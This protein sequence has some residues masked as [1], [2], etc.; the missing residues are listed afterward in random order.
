MH[1]ITNVFSYIIAFVLLMVI[2]LF[3]L[4]QNLVGNQKLLDRP[5]KTIGRLIP[6]VFGIRVKVSYLCRP[7][8]L[9]SYIFIANH[10]NIFDGFILYGY[11][12]H[13][14]RGVELDSH[15]KWP[16]WG[17]IVK[18]LGN[19][20]ISHNNTRSAMESLEKAEE[21]VRRGTSIV[22]LPEGHRTRT[23]SLLPF[24][25][26]PFRIAK[27]SG[28]DIVPIALKGAWERKRVTSPFVK[29]GVVELI[30]GKVISLEEHSQLS[31]KELRD[32]AFRVISDL[33]Q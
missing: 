24:H 14:I 11:I 20:P 23:G 5:I 9:K 25:R 8:P 28:A 16:F 19:I 12:S 15:F 4:I 26:G 7:D 18:K 10:I 13:F 27:H 33:L 17:S 32:K 22:I 29:P 3:I 21:A 31:E 2:F 6:G 30:F 1:R